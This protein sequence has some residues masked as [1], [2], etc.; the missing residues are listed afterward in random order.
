MNVKKEKMITMIT[1]TSKN[2]KLNKIKQICSL[3]T[4]NF[5]LMAQEQEM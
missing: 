3:Y 5:A 1:A 2:I 4:V